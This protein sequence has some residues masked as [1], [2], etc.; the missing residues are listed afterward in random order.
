MNPWD[1]IRNCLQQKIS[2]ESYDNWLKGTAFLALDETALLGL[3]A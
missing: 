3:G 1:Q 2:S